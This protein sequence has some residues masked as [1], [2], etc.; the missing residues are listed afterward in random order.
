VNERKG[1]I[2]KVEAKRRCVR[3]GFI[4]GVDWINLPQERDKW[5]TVVNTQMNFGVQQDS[6]VS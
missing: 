2:R 4:G 1:A 5:R 6:G 3:M